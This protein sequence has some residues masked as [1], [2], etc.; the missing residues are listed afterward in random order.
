MAI[1]DPYALVLSY[2]TTLSELELQ[3]LL[4]VIKI[5]LQSR[6]DMPTPEDEIH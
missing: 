4:E 1:D 5:E 2:I 6:R 3:D